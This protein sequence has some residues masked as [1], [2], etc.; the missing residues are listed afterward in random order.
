M[1]NLLIVF[2][3]LT[4]AGCSPK[5]NANATDDGFGLLYSVTSQQQNVDKL[6][7]I[8]DPGAD[9]TAWIEQ[10][11]QF[12]QEVTKQLEAWKKAGK[13][14]SLKALGLPPAELE[15]RERA[16]KRTTGDLLFSEDVSLRLSLVIAQL[17]ALGY[18][19]DLSYAIAAETQDKAIQET[20]T[21]W[22]SKFKELNAQGMT[23]LE[24]PQITSPE[25][26]P[27]KVPS[28]P[29]HR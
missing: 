3:F 5:P 27:A 19:S 25:E 21:Q 9:I 15:A 8:K 7:W 6:L 26:S 17:K 14:T 10:I 28:A 11:A 4:L 12:N 13:I 29:Q 23:L 24:T 18:C 2:A 1:K 22:E 20:A 16:T